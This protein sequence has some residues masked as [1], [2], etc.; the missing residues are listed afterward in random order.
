MTRPKSLPAADSANAGRGAGGDLAASRLADRRSGC[1]P[2][3]RP[4]RGAT[5]PALPRM[6]ERRRELGLT[7]AVAAAEAEVP[8]TWWRDV[9]RGKRRAHLKR[10]ERAA[11]VLRATVDEIFAPADP[12]PVPRF[13]DCGCGRSF[14]PTWTE[15]ERGRRFYSLACARASVRKHPEPGSRV[16]ARDGCEV[17]FRPTPAQAAKGWGR[18][19][20]PECY[21]EARR[22]HPPAPPA[23]CECG[24]GRMIRPKGSDAARGRGRFYSKSCAMRATMAEGTERRKRAIVWLAHYGWK[25]WGPGKRKHWLERLSK[26]VAELREKKPGPK[27]DL[28]PDQQLAIIEYDARRKSI[29]W[30]ADR[31]DVDVPKGRVERFLRWHHAK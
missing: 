16:C 14:T 12:V 3:G 2:S 21:C 9:E 13:C 31:S 11:G 17:E 29:R 19:H 10:A 25:A 7:R 23:P 27:F 8:F 1:A 4:R 28:S 5:R 15:Q 6:R 30:I 24:C 18:Y 20:S 22:I 26:Q